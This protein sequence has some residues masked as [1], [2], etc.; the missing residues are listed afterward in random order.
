MRSAITLGVSAAPEGV[1]GVPV[2]IW[3]NVQPH[4]LPLPDSLSRT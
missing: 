3:A 2:A 4:S 1:R